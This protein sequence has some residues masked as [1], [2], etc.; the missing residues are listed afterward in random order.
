MISTTS[1]TT[2]VY[3][4]VPL[5]NGSNILVFNGDSKHLVAYLPVQAN[6]GFLLPKSSISPLKQSY[7][8]NDIVCFDSSLNPDEKNKDRW[9]GDDGMYVDSKY[10]IGQMIMEGERHLHLKIDGQTITSERFQV[11]VP[12]EIKLNKGK[13]D[14]LY[15]GEQ[16]KMDFENQFETKEIT[17]QSEIVSYKEKLLIIESDCL[18]VELI[19]LYS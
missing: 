6:S 17:K 10:G 3:E 8:I 18:C 14:F 19:I 2:Q 4:I 7:Y 12:N 11:Q 9:S 15:D 16:G 1:N 13:N 5:K